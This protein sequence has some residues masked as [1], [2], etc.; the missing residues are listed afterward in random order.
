MSPSI[1]AAPACRRPANEFR[2]PAQGAFDVMNRW[3][4]RL[5]PLDPATVHNHLFEK[6]L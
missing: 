1:A 2:P 3:A 5:Q 6:M 4:K